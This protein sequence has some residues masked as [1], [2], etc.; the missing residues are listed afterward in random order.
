MNPF[1]IHP[2]LTD[3][4]WRQ[5]WSSGYGKRLTFQRSWVRI[6]AL[7]TGWTKFTFICCKNC[8]D[9]CLKRPKIN[10]KE[11]GVGPCLKNGQFT[12]AF[13]NMPWITT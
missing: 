6:Q 5:P 7:Y 10:E 3:N 12:Q 9:V 1:A 13:T 11:A 8:N 4:F 2:K